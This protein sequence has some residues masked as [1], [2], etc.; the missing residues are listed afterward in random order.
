MRYTPK[1]KKVALV[2]WHLV[3]GHSL[4]L[5]HSGGRLLLGDSVWVT[6][7]MDC[8]MSTSYMYSQDLI[9]CFMFVWN[10]W[11]SVE[12]A[13]FYLGVSTWTWTVNNNNNKNNFINLHCADINLAFSSAHYHV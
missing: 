1:S 4:L 2:D 9:L 12:E 3:F 5:V 10:L 13:V 6:V 7:V 11:L 8:S